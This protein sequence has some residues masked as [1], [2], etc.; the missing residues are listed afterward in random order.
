[1]SLLARLNCKISELR[2]EMSRRKIVRTQLKE[3]DRI[4]ERLQKR[5]VLSIVALRHREI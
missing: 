3:Q 2:Q 1:M 4:R 5:R